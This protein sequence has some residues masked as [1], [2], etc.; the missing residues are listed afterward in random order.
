VSATRRRINQERRVVVAGMRGLAPWCARCGRSDVVVHGHER[1]G[2]AQG[3]DITRPDDLLCNHCN[4]W[5]ESFPILA[6]WQGWKNSRKNP[7]A[8][9]ITDDLCPPGAHLLGEQCE[10]AA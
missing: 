10:V 2:R 3:G 6:A 8:Q 1:T 4:E 5:A 7:T 9:C